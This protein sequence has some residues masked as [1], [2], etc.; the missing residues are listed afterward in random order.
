MEEELIDDEILEIFI[1]EG[2]E[3][4]ESIN[5]NLPPWK[6]DPNNESSR[7]EVRRAFHTLKGSGRMVQAYE[8]G[9]LAWSI[10]NMLN[11]VIDGTIRM[12]AGTFTLVEQV[13]EVLPSMLDLFASKKPQVLNVEPFM[14]AADQYAKGL[15]P[16]PVDLSGKVAMRSELIVEVSK[17]TEEFQAKVLQQLSEMTKTTRDLS[18]AV[19]GINQEL[20]VMK[21]NY[22]ALDTRVGMAGSGGT[23]PGLRKD[24]LLLK[25]DY[26]KVNDDV[27]RIV[28]GVN[29]RVVKVEK[30]SR[31]QLAKQ[32]RQLN[33][34]HN[35]LT[36]AVNKVHL[37]VNDVMR[38]AK[39]WAFGAAFFAVTFLLVIE[40]FLH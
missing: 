34:I 35:T 19:K 10:E 5:Q 40:L 22:R 11:R 12:N 33:Q 24:F 2:A 27:Q 3:V 39:A 7:A 26:D 32:A 36:K 13:V 1:E 15:V 4:L 30:E 16:E 18:M 29:Q 28:V 31:L 6:S 14:S 25:Q 20:M 8:I 37:S 17:D 21:A 9:E 38:S 23:D